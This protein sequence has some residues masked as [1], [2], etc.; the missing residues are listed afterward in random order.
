MAQT[1][2]EKAAYNKA[3]YEANR[4][5][6][7]AYNKAYRE[8]NKEEVRA[9]KEAYY[10]ANKEELLAYHEAYYEANKEAVLAKNKAYYEANKEAVLVKHKAWREANKE[11]LR[12]YRK[13][14]KDKVQAS[15]ARRRA[16]KINQVPVHLRDCTT[17]KQ[18]IVQ[19]YK[20]RSLLSKATGIQHHVDHMWPLADG[21]PHWSGNLQ[22][23]PAEENL[24]KN[25][26]VCEDIK[27]TVIQSLY[28]FESDRP[29]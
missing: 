9:T 23:I 24:R 27:A 19:I 1:K 10:K 5:K 3:W 14:N 6:K 12:A 4:Q 26:S 29:I 16:A 8:A 2:E 28:S 7:L 18:R 11:E 17:E 15:R 21:G 22:V 13:A 25:A 20:L